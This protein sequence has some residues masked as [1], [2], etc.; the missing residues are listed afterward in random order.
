MS[1]EAVF[2]LARSN[3]FCRVGARA[4]RQWD[5]VADASNLSP[6]G[7]QPALSGLR[8][9]V[10]HLEHLRPRLVRPQRPLVSLMF[11]V[12]TSEDGAFSTSGAKK[13]SR[14]SRAAGADAAHRLG[15]ASPWL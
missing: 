2:F 15:A 14:S 1:F 9:L 5:T 8:E 13:G 4:L 6:T 11:I 12:G 3:L 10:S 7:V